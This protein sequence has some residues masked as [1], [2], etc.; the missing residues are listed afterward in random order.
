MALSVTLHGIATV[1]GPNQNGRWATADITTTDGSD[2]IVYTVP[3]TVEYLIGAIS[4]LNRT[5]QA[6]TD[7][8]IA[9]ATADIPLD[10]EFIEWRTSMVPRGVL[11]RT[12]LLLEP[13]DRVIVRVGAGYTPPTIFTL[14]SSTDM[15]E[16]AASG[17]G[18]NI[19]SDFYE[20]ENAIAGTSGTA[21]ITANSTGSLAYDA[22]VT[23]T[24]NSNEVRIQ[25]QGSEIVN[26]SST[27]GSGNSA[28]SVSITN[29]DEIQIDFTSVDPDAAT[30][31]KL[32][33]T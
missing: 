32:A 28:A 22:T 12:Q 17:N 3:A 27:G 14:D 9:I 4:V 10:S 23:G 8:N 26:Q 7:V 13:G 33:I 31:V 6:A 1:A 24:G 20:I 5:E 19:V 30:Q 29:G 25:V 18:T 16:S 21:T 2:N 11:E 15:G